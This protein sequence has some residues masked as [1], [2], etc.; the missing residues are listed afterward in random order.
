MNTI[1]IRD[2]K[3]LIR[4]PYTQEFVAAQEI[5]VEGPQGT[6]KPRTLDIIE[7]ALIAKGYEILG[8]A[9]ETYT[10]TVSKL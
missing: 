3:T 9:E 7:A 8:R 1:T 6:R 10:L 2:S 5:T 4:K